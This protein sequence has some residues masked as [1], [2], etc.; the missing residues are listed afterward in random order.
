MGKKLGRT[1]DEGT[2]M[3]GWEEALGFRAVLYLHLLQSRWRLTLQLN[4]ARSMGEVYIADTMAAARL[5][6]GVLVQRLS[7]LAGVAKRLLSQRNSNWKS[8]LK[9][10]LQHAIDGERYPL[11][12][13]NG[14]AAAAVRAQAAAAPAPAAPLSVL[15]CDDGAAASAADSGS[16]IEL[17]SDPEVECEIEVYQADL[18]S[19]TE[20]DEADAT[21]LDEVSDSWDDSDELPLRQRVAFLAA[22][23]RALPVPPAPAPIAPSPSAQAAAATLADDSSGSDAD[24]EEEEDPPATTITSQNASHTREVSGHALSARVPTSSQTAP[25]PRP[26]ASPA[27]AAQ[28]AALIAR[29]ARYATP[30]SLAL[31]HA[32]LLPAP[33]APAVAPAAVA[34]ATVGSSSAPPNEGMAQVRALLASFQMASYADVFERMG[35][36]LPFPYSKTRCIY[37]YLYIC[38][39]IYIYI[40][41]SRTTCSTH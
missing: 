17:G 16:E 23:G 33:P 6:E 2:E 10:I 25:A 18:G 32:H 14:A 38:M 9:T 13:S 24:D 36:D 1:F 39:Y 21:E 30:I 31:P 28:Q 4:R 26:R 3:P 19:E 27:Q 5:L 11:P 34:P 8:A 35:Y 15:A 29:P 37:I 40:Y 41:S 22:S 12:T 7:A 20:L